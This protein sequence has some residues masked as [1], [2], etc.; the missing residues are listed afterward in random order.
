MSLACST[1]RARLRAHPA[2]FVRRE[3]AWSAIAVGR[4]P[5]FLVE[6]DR[7]GA[8]QIA[9]TMTVHG[10][11]GPHAYEI[12]YDWSKH[13]LEVTISAGSGRPLHRGEICTISGQ[14]GYCK[15]FVVIE[16]KRKGL[17]WSA[18]CIAAGEDM[19]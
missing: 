3:G 2:R 19:P 10:L 6:R 1:S 15:D 9:T 5:G 4:A 17:A 14:G 7:C 16:V 13:A 11:F 18:R 8:D 12:V